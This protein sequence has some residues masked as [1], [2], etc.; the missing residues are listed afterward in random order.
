MVVQLITLRRN[1]PMAADGEE[2]GVLA[3]AVVEHR[4]R[5]LALA[6]HRLVHRIDTRRMRATR[7]VGFRAA[8]PLEPCLHAFGVQRLAGMGCAGKGDL[9]V[10]QA[11]RIGSAGFQQ[12]QRLHH[13]K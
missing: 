12:R 13:F 7:E 2:P 1:V 11:E 5:F 6:D 3:G 9:F 10:G 4:R 8:D